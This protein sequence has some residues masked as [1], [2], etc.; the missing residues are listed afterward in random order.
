M[1]E[2]Q[3]IWALSLGRQD[4]LEKEMTIRFGIHADSF[5]QAIIAD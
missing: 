2:G 4:P 1:Q 3:E 5:G